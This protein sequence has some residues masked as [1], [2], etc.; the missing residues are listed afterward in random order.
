M[1][2]IRYN[3]WLH[4][5]GTGGVSQDAGGNIGIGTTA[6]LI[7][8]GAGNT[9]IL[10]VGVV[11][12]NYIYG[13]VQGAIEGTL[14]D[15]IVHAGDTNTKIGFSA[16][17]TFQVHTGGSARLTV[18]D[19][20]TTVTGDLRLNDNENIYL[21]DGA[22]LEIRSGGNDGVINQANADLKIQRGGSGKVTFKSTGSHFLDDVFVVDNI[23]HEGDTDT[24]IRFPAADTINLETGGTPRLRIDSGRVLIGTTDAG[25]S[26]ADNLT[27]ADSGTCGITIRSGN[28]TE[29]NIFF[30][31]GTTGDSRYR[32]ILR[33]EHNNDAMV[34]KTAGSER[35]RITSTGNVGIGTDA[36]A[37]QSGY[38]HSSGSTLV[39]S[40]FGSNSNWNGQIRLGHTGSGFLIDHNASST[41]TT[42]LRNLYGA[43]NG[44]ALTKIESGTIKLCTGTGYAD[45]VHIDSTGK[46]GLGTTPSEQFHLLKSHNGHTRA[47]IQN[48]WG[49]NATAQLKLISPTDE[50]QLIK[51]A[52]G[53]AAINLSN[54]STMYMS[55]GGQER[56]KIRGDSTNQTT[57][58]VNTPA[59]GGVDSQY[60]TQVFAK[61]GNYTNFRVT[62]TQTSWGS[63]FLKMYV[64]GHDGNSAHRWV[65]GYCNNG[66]STIRHV[67]SNDS[68]NFGSG[69]ITHISGQQWRY[70]ISVNSGT[71]THPVMGVELF[72]GGNGNLLGSG[73]VVLAIT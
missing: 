72:F 65:A 10:N 8:V 49:A 20:A 68:G 26:T 48:N 3:Q 63:F 73:A 33:Y 23:V 19:S 4:N 41:T 18:T 6:P 44:A 69:S 37:A 70:D 13:T 40:C 9:T 52:S 56:L 21:G 64:A 39:L 61:S 2:D 30:A 29:G 12:A 24:K 1:S 17:D 34:L 5:S 7:P 45:A 71:A 57:H 59:G 31:D 54:N 58:I 15:W 27:I 42:T 32:G 47:V 36:I 38:T 25:D 62:V 53:A 50:L 28:T 60:V 55:I 43:S 11:T 35:L 51:Y 67:L 66:F 46:M 16:N 14:D 22:D